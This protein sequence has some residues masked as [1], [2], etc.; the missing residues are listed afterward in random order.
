MSHRRR[1]RV[2]RGAVGRG[3]GGAHAGGRGVQG[4]A[5]ARRE[6]RRGL[7]AGVRGEGWVGEEREDKEGG[8]SGDDD[9]R[10]R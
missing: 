5:G 2:E 3:D 8:E 1:D 6:R 4:L 7:D 10:Q 9:D